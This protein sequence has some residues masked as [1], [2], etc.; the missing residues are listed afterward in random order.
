[1]LAMFS[2]VWLEKKLS[3]SVHGS[4]QRDHL[5]SECGEP[6]RFS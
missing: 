5:G 6:G 2:T 3:G 1:M 4:I